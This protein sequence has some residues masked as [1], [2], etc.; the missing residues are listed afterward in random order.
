[1]LESICSCENQERNLEKNLHSKRNTAPIL[2]NL[3]TE[4]MMRELDDKATGIIIGGQNYNN[5]RYADDAV[6]VC[7]EEQSLQQVI[8]KIADICR[9]YGMEMNVKKTK[10]LVISKS[11]NTSCNIT[12]DNT[13]VEQVAQY[14][15]LGSL[16]TEDGKCDMDIK[17]RIGMAKDTFL[18][19]KELLKG[20]ISLQT[21]KL[22]LNC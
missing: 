1:M 2:F 3:Y 7:N 21:K 10:T 9:S 8:Q 11:G 4:F 6:F 5:I 14:K 15:Y 18:K 20:N 16:I 12:V 13:P 17:T 22:M 19:H